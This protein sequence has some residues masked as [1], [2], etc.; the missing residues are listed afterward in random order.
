LGERWFRLQEQVQEHH[1]WYRGRR[2]LLERLL[3]RLVPEGRRARILDVGSGVGVH[4]R[5]LARWGDAVLFDRS[6]DALAFA[7]ARARG[8]CCLGD[9][10]RL[11]FSDGSF[12]L[13]LAL[14]VLEHLE[15][16]GGALAELERVVAPEGKLLV[17]V[18]AFEF[19]WGPQ[20]DVSHHLR[21][22]TR[23]ELVRRVRAAGFGVLRA[24][25][26]NFALFGPILAARRLIRLL[27]LSVESEN[28]LTTPATNAVLEKIF[29][30]ESRL[31]LGVDYPFGVSLAL[32]ARSRKS[33]MAYP[34]ARRSAL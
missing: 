23:P 3:P 26:F 4:A 17:M 33:A 25:F 30:A 14:D 21:R 29:S 2:T 24:W 9:A 27:R 13:V 32:V 15:D 7:R 20:D 12:D 19:L 28:T 18:P 1:W 6:P 22:Y 16:D 11:P 8:S 10:G 34:S 5:L 31:S